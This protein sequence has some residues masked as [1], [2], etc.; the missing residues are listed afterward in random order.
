MQSGERKEDKELSDEKTP[1]LITGVEKLGE[2]PFPP[3]K[4]R[5]FFRGTVLGKRFYVGD[6]P[7]GMEPGLLA[8]DINK[9]LIIYL[10]EK[11]VFDAKVF[12]IH[13]K[14]MMS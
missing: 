4:T 10:H 11:G 3:R 6:K 8:I 13:P 7:G 9:S 2:P 12:L 1:D 14:Q 5:H